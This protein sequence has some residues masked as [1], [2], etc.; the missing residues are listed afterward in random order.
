[1]VH[2]DKLS[3][4]ASSAPSK[5]TTA[6]AL[7]SPAEDCGLYVWSRLPDVD[8][9]LLFIEAMIRGVGARLEAS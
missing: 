4:G 5:L 9:S 8:L 7:R 1:M 3:S 2:R 6:V